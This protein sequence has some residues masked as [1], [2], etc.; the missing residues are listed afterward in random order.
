M[1][2]L[3]TK[4]LQYKRWERILFSVILVIIGI[5]G[6]TLLAFAPSYQ[7]YVRFTEEYNIQA[8]GLQTSA[9]TTDIKYE[10]QLIA[11]VD[12]VV[13]CI[14]QS[15]RYFF[16]SQL[17][18]GNSSLQDVRIT[19]TN[20]ALAPELLAGTPIENAYEFLC[21]PVLIDANG[22]K[23]DGESLIGQTVSITVKQMHYTEEFFTNPDVSPT[24]S[25]T[26]T[27][28]GRIT[29]VYRPFEP[30]DNILIAGFETVGEM[31]QYQRG[32]LYQFQPD[33]VL[34]VYADSY[35]NLS[36]VE[37]ELRSME[38]SSHPIFW[39]DKTGV[40]LI[41]VGA[42]TAF[43]LIGLALFWIIWVLLRRQLAAR[44]KEIALLK[45]TGIENIRIG[46]GLLSNLLQTAVIP[47]C[48]S[49]AFFWI[50]SRILAKLLFLGLVG[51]TPGPSGYIVFLVG[52]VGACCG[53]IMALLPG[54]T[55]LSPA[56]LLREESI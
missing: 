12:H 49:G 10:Q 9:K 11:S 18:A 47:V 50:I 13:A 26:K 27:F 42:W 45:A 23:I 30:D 52:M 5:A 8:R 56:L 6:L 53:I 2:K 29:G 22:Q 43:T 31:S 4:A 37:S 16:A 38:Y 34:I 15:E 54:I 46:R 3:L 36:K 41:T 24:I 44:S 17:T 14:P 25:D 39:L 32:N 7:D 48:L 28:T 20:E 21:P 40:F 55:R 1:D 35:S 51:Y 19:G 33:T